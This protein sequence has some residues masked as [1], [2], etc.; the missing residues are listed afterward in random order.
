MDGGITP[1]MLR[2]QVLAIVAGTAF[3]T[4]GAA[5]CAVAASRYRSGGRVFLWLG[6]WSGI[7][8]MQELTR[9]PAFVASLPSA[10]GAGLPVLTVLISYLILAAAL[11]V[12]WELTRGLLKRVLAAFAAAALVVA[13]AGVGVHVSGG[14]AGV[15]QSVNALLGVAALLVLLTVT[16]LPVR[17]A[18]R[19]LVRPQRG[20]LLAGTL[21]FAVQALYSNVARTLGLSSPRAL[22]W[23][24]FAALI[25]SFGYV[26]LRAVIE[27]EHRLVSIESELAVARRLQQ[28]ILP[29]GPP[30]LSGVR[31]AAAY[32][33]MTAVAGDFYEFLPVDSHRAGFLVADVSG[34]GVP[35]ALVASMVKVAVHSVADAAHDPGELLRRLGRALE[36]HLRHQYVTVA[37]LWLDTRTMTARYSAAGH[38]PLLHWRAAAGAAVPILSNGLL[39]GVVP[40][41]EYPVCEMAFE[42]GDRFL[43]YTDGLTEPENAAGEPFGDARLATVLR[44]CRAGPAEEVSRRLRAEVAAWTPQSVAQQDDITLLVVDVT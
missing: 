33:P 37:Y 19:Y 38:P 12:W 36:P 21:V 34:H 32:E 6:V 22:D 25:L 39:F 24:G 18:R 26:A 23:V 41:S 4:A 44:E 31:I 14:D 8:G 40:D 9:T 29:A 13:A 11:L 5:A 7:Y 2:E 28:S 42:G 20:V 1:A 10:L 17:L 27:R 35:A 30:R 15:L 16:A 43:L 3:I